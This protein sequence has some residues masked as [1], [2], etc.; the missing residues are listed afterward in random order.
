M[1]GS[2]VTPILLTTNSI[3]P[4]TD[5]DFAQ[6]DREVDDISADINREKEDEIKE[7]IKIV[8]GEGGVTKFITHARKGTEGSRGGGT[9][10]VGR[11][12]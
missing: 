11:N 1:N 10:G 12:A 3:V 7:F 5:F 6:V 8:S 2:W 4:S 9:G